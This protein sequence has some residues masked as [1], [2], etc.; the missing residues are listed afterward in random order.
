MMSRLNV[1]IVGASVA[2]PT[3]AY[4][5]AKAGANITIIERFPRMRTSG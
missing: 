4:W 3:A 5:L 1:L 2:G